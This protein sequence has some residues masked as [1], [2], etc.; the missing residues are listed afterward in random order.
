M[1][2]WDSLA[3]RDRPDVVHVIGGERPVGRCGVGL[4]LLRTR[5]SGDHGADAGLRRQ[6]GDGQLGHVPAVLGG[7][8]REPGH[9]G[10]VAV[11]HVP[12]TSRV[13][14]SAEPAVRGRRLALPVPAAEH[15][16]GQGEERQERQPE[17]AGAWQEFGGGLL[18]EQ[19]LAVLY[20]C[21]HRQP[22]VAGDAEPLLDGVRRHVAHAH[23]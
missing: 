3:P 22:G 23:L 8:G 17:S 16:R 9:A 18:A 15:A 1:F 14:V 12:G 4:S 19:V 2:L 11:D 7:P 10:G 21:R 20:R 13:D 6:P 5:G